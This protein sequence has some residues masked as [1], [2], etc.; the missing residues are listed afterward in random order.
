MKNLFEI[1]ASALPGTLRHFQK[2]AK[3][4]GWK[5]ASLIRGS[6]E[7]YI[8]AVRPDGKEIRFCSC[9]VPDASYFSGTLADDKFATYQLLKTAGIKQPETIALSKGAYKDELKKLLEKHKSIVIKPADGAHGNDVFVGIT[10]YENALKI[11]DYVYARN[12]ES[13]ILAMEQVFADTPEV[14]V[15]CIDYHFVKAFARIPAQVTGDG[16]HT[17]PEL[18][19]IE[20]ATI[21]TA[22]YKSNLAFIDGPASAEYIEKHQLANYVPKSG[23][24][25]QVV[26]ACNTGKGGTMI[27]ITDTFSDAKRKESEKIARTME[28]PV[29]GIDHFGDYVIEVN[30][31]PAL[32]HPVPG[33]AAEICIEKWVEYLETVRIH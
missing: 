8:L 2:I 31:T 26:A 11:N 10:D 22:P 3:R 16:T 7:S 30:S 5:K 23:E 1:P 4:R 21:R 15:I 13:I 19:K 18:V 24:K 9:T 28:L 32:Y 33:E 20:N 17:V 6:K 27:D 14:R 12:P 29:I 25:V